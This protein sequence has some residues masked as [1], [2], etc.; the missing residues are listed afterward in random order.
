MKSYSILNPPKY[1]NCVAFSNIGCSYDMCE[2]QFPFEVSE[3]R[4]AKIGCVH[5]MRRMRK[6]KHSPPILY[7]GPSWKWSS[8][9]LRR[10]TSDEASQYPISRRLG[11]PQS[12]SRRFGEERRSSLCRIGQRFLCSLFT[13]P[14]KPS[15]PKRFGLVT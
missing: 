10:C 3:R 4:E 1:C 11:A 8:S 9:L 7:F 13:V 12:R 5:A 2:I 15:R 6:C 14:N